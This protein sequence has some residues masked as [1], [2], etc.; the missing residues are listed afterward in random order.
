ENGITPDVVGQQY[1]PLG[2]TDFSSYISA[3][4]AA[5]PDFLFLGIF[6][7]DLITFIRQA[8]GYGLFGKVLTGGP[9]ATDTL[10]AM[11]G[12]TPAGMILWGRAPFFAIS[13]NGVEEFVAAY[14]KKFNGWP[15]EWP[16]LAYSSVQVW[17]AG[18]NKAGTFD[19]A[20]V[21]GAI[22][23]A[24]IETIRGKLTFRTCDHQA[25]ARCYIGKV[26]ATV[27]P[28]YGFPLLEDVAVIDPEKTMMP[29]T[30][31]ESLQHR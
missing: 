18:V 30:M 9:T 15:S 8:K 7:G 12:D 6:A 14:R 31:A 10:L 21:A 27:D 20:K 25:D 1:P 24:T 23:G 22:S 11:K 29:C 17:A 16:I 19:G 13:G 26:A 28:K 2:T 4:L 5:K 3:A